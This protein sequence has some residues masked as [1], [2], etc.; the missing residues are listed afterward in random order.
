MVRGE[1]PSHHSGFYITEC[2]WMRKHG[3]RTPEWKLHVA[4]EPDFHFKPEIELYNMIL[5]PNEDHNVADENPAVVTAL[6]AQMDA[7]IAR[8]E[9]ETGRPNPMFTNLNWHGGAGG[10]EGPFTSSQQAYD[11]LHIG[12]PGAAQRLQGR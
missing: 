6:R 1:V 2:T 10:V 9:A 4:L 5:D 12:D 8:R 7:W 3:W 11:S